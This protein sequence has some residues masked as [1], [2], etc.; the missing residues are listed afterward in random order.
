MALSLKEWERHCRISSV[1]TEIRQ[2]LETYN[3]PSSVW[4]SEIGQ[5]NANLIWKAMNTTNGV[6]YKKQTECKH[7]GFQISAFVTIILLSKMTQMPRISKM[8]TY[9]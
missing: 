8:L 7:S 4:N 3:I 2:L 5:S 6:G 1:R 9:E